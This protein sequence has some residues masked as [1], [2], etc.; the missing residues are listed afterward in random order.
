MYCLLPACPVLDM[1]KV[2]S[3]FASRQDEPR[4]SH[5]RVREPGGSRRVPQTWW[6]QVIF[7]RIWRRVLNFE[8]HHDTAVFLTRNH[9]LGCHIPRA[10]RSHWCVA[11][12]L[13]TSRQWHRKVCQKLCHLCFVCSLGRCL[14]RACCLL[15]SS[16]PL[17]C[18][19]VL[20]SL[21]SDLLQSL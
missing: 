4:Q 16:L 10:W 13:V 20:R 17:S 11:C 18:S 21:P 14:V 3:S 15:A 8:T 19:P 7:R 2:I 9:H 6:L 12:A 5:W 1:P